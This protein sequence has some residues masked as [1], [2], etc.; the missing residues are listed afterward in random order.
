MVRRLLSLVLMVVLVAPAVALC[1]GEVTTPAA[2]TAAHD[3]CPEE[4]NGS[5]AMPDGPS[6]AS[7]NESCCRMSDDAQHRVPSPVQKISTAPPSTVSMPA[8]S[9]HVEG[10][11]PLVHVAT[12]PP[13]ADHVPRHLLLSVLIV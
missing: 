6:R 3:C 4:L 13:A 5:M 1:A 8:W 12:A 11:T 2:Q 9:Q 7:M 10:L